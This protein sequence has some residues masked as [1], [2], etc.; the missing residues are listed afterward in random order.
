MASL[1]AMIEAAERRLDCPPEVAGAVLPLAVSTFRFG[2]VSL[3][4]ATATFVATA[5]GHPPG[6]AQFALGGAVVIL[7][8]IGVPGLPAAAVMYAASAPG[9]VA[10]GAP[11]E[12]FPLML[13]ISSGPQDIF[14]TVC[15][16][17]HDLAAGTVLQ[18]WLG[19]PAE[20]NAP[21]APRPPPR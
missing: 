12:L 17:S 15:N 5:T 2:N 10:M 19:R 8:N 18:R 16:V 11:L 14:T 13:A 20:P 1:P 9:W 3:V 21:R 7:T 4:M 6:L